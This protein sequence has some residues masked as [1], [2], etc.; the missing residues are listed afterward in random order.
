MH[1]CRRMDYS[2]RKQTMRDGVYITR[3]LRMRSGQNITN[4]MRWISKSQT[5]K[6]FIHSVYV[7][8]SI[9][10]TWNWPELT[11]LLTYLLYLFLAFNNLRDL[12]NGNL[13]LRPI[14]WGVTMATA[15]ISD[16]MIKGLKWFFSSLRETCVWFC[17]SSSVAYSVLIHNALV[18]PTAYPKVKRGCNYPDLT[19]KLTVTPR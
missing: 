17:P 19:D 9:L 1:V 2:Y 16:S 6:T 18:L 11:S 3:G 5:V 15:G 8:P 13:N 4:R 10:Y 14:L 12:P 7:S